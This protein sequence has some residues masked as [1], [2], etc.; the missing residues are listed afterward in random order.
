M[1]K[2]TNGEALAHLANEGLSCSFKS[3]QMTEH[4][5]AGRL[6]QGHV[7]GHEAEENHRC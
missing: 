2:P 4:L 3:A 1:L 6:F 5:E 7:C